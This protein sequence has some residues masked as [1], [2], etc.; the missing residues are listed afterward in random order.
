MAKACALPPGISDRLQGM[1]Q[2]FSFA[3]V[4]SDCSKPDMPIVFASSQ[5]YLMTGYQADEV[6]KCGGLPLMLIRLLSMV[7]GCCHYPYHE[8]A[9]SPAIRS[10][11]KTVGFFKGRK[12][13]A[14]R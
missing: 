2:D 11:V 6:R 13:S 12:P 7:A 8:Q 14:G 1:L 10:S 4:V 3:F 5:L 9:T